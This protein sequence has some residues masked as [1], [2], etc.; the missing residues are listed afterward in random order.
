ME[1][2]GQD[3]VGGGASAV[4]LPRCFGGC[5]RRGHS[6]K[7]LNKSTHLGCIAKG[8]EPNDLLG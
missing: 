5:L 4:S 1:E 6:M 2:A 7:K 3:A 8:S